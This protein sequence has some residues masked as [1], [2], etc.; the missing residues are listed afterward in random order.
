[1]NEKPPTNPDPA[2]DPVAPNPGDP[3]PAM[4]E[5]RTPTDPFND[6]RIPPQHSGTRGV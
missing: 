1:M 6:E 5:P 4:P 2:N 3:G